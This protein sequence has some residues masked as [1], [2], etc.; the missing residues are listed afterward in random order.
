MANSDKQVID[1]LLQ[2]KAIKI[3]VAKP[4]RWASGWNSPIYC[5]N[6]KIL[7]YPEIRNIIRDHFINIINDKFQNAQ[8]IAGIATGAIALSA[9]IAD[10]LNLPLV[11]VRPTKKDHGL[12]NIIEGE[13]IPDQ[14]VVVVEDLVSTG[15]SSLKAVNVLRENQ[16]DILGMVAIFSYGF[17]S[18][19]KRFNDAKCSLYTL[20]NYKALMKSALELGYIKQNEHILI[21][22]WHENPENRNV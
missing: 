13:I 18:T 4:F 15:G 22:R 17:K 19:V 8:V 6:R 14:R 7:S 12:G 5:D 3:N 16:C 21:E 11:Y 10:S 9:L 2:I 1:L 20:S